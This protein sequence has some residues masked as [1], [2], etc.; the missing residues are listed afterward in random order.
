MNNHYTLFLF[1]I[2]IVH[3]LFG[4]APPS[5]VSSSDKKTSTGDNNTQNDNSIQ[6]SSKK[7]QAISQ[8]IVTYYNNTAKITLSS[9]SN[10]SGRVKYIIT[11]RPKNG[12]LRGSAQHYTYTS[13]SGFIGKDHFLFRVI[14][15]SYSTAGDVLKHCSFFCSLFALECC[16]SPTVLTDIFR[17]SPTGCWRG[18]VRGVMGVITCRVRCI[19]SLP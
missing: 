6:N 1:P 16:N 4:C 12:I 2:V 9:K 15:N 3:I 17:P 10:G 5:M 19:A 8:D 11:Q 7:P 13:Y 18:L 14:Q